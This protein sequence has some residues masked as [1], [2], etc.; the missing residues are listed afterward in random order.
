MAF[1]LSTGERMASESFPPVDF[2]TAF[3]LR[4]RR[5]AS[6][7]RHQTIP[8]I[9]AANRR[10]Y[11]SYDAV[12]FQGS[13]YSNEVLFERSWRLAQ[14][15]HA[16]GVEKGDRIVVNLLNCP[17]IW[18]C[19]LACS[20]LGAVI[21]PTVPALTVHELG[22]MVS[23]CQPAVIVTSRE[24]AEHFRAHHADF[25]SIKLVISGGKEETELRTAID[26]SEP[27]DGSVNTQ[28]DDLAA[29][30]YTSGT[31]G[32]PK[33]VML[34]QQSLCRQACLNHGF[35]V[36]PGEDSRIATLLMPLPMC[37][38]F[39]LAVAL[40]SLLMGNLMVVMERFDPA[41]ALS[42]VREHRIRIVPA[43][44]TMLVR[45]L[46]NEGAASTCGSVVQWDCGG[47]A[48]AVDLLEQV[49]RTLGGLVTEGWGLS[50]ASS[51]VVQNV[52]GV[53]RKPGSVGLVLPGLELAVRTLDGR[54]CRPEEQGELLVRG[55][56]VM[57][58]YWNRPEATAKALDAGGFL[59]TGDIGLVDDDGYCFIIGRVDDLII[60]GGQ[61]IS[62]RELE[63]TIQ[64]HPAV[65]EVAVVGLP[66]PELGAIAAAFVVPNRGTSLDGPAII[67]FCRSRLARHK[68]PA[69]VIT[70]DQLPYNST[71]K[72]MKSELRRISET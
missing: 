19:Y 11:G 70:V 13:R 67:E 18:I 53:P 26:T 68:V 16:A 6:M 22:F 1:A 24:K 12:L 55:E 71:G 30:I 32:K 41:V 57:R 34:S 43:V 48:L 49:E 51:A 7:P 21:V 64:E 10:S 20:A 27:Y 65:R 35:Y 42:L 23:D 14:R 66:D 33:G 8:D 56:T 31:T 52:P 39:G 2:S 3:E 5:F 36:G 47:S 45:L 54:D 60:R 58:G 44:P 40:T 59:H 37:H 28:P 69:R 17:D 38:I 50:E 15:W 29:I 61:N 4:D 72:V 9:V 62:P 46:A 25:P 63:E